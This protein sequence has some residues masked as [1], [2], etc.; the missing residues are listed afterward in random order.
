MKKKRDKIESIACNGILDDILNF[1]K[2]IEDFGN[3]VDNHPSSGD[4]KKWFQTYVAA[5]IKIPDLPEVAASV[6]IS[7]AFYEQIWKRTME[8]VI[9]RCEPPL[10]KS[11]VDKV[12]DGYKEIVER[13][14]GEMVT[15]KA[16]LT[17]RKKK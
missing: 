10:T 5:I 1:N 3:E 8:D 9:S 15:A 12:H 13:R 4:L 11:S 14:I 2:E 7:A 16:A 6:E 17:K